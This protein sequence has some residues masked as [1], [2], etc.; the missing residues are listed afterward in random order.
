MIDLHAAKDIAFDIVVAA[1]VL[2][3]VLPPWDAPAIAGLPTFQKYY[4][5][6]IYFVGYVAINARST[7]YRSISQQNQ[8]DKP[9][10]LKP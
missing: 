10:D 6:A 5:I 8:Q 3:T 1:S 2:H 9:E 4:R 7:V